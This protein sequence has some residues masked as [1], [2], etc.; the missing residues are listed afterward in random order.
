MTPGDYLFLY[1]DGVTEALNRSQEFF[2][3]ER[4]LA[5][6]GNRTQMDVEGITREI[7]GKI[8]EYTGSAPQSDDIAMMLIRFN[9]PGEQLQQ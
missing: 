6:L 5:E 9:G 3:D 2:S 4:L 8:S 7:R 1:T